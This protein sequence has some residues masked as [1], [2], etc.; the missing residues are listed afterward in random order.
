MSF[1][2]EP[3]HFTDYL[4]DKAQEVPSAGTDK[5]KKELTRRGIDTLVGMLIFWERAAGIPTALQLNKHPQVTSTKQ[6]IL[7]E[8]KTPASADP[9]KGKAIRYTANRIAALA[10]K[11]RKKSSRTCERMCAWWL[12]VAHG[13]ACGSTI[14]GG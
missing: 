5:A 6:D 4:E 12:L 14:L 8:L 3:V 10:R 2:S 7:A 11:V 9:Y 1:P 13:A